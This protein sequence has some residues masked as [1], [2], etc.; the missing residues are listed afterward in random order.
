MTQNG[1]G[2]SVRSELNVAV[3]IGPI[4]AYSLR[5]TCREDWNA[6]ASALNAL[7]CNTLKNGRRMNVAVRR[8]DVWPSGH[9]R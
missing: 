8:T 6:R 5:Q 4:T 2:V 9:R 1:Q 3:R 7:T